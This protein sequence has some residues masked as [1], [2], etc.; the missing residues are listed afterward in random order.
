M[1]KKTEIY[2]I[3]FNHV[4]TE[5]DMYSTT[6][7]L[8]VPANVNGLFVIPLRIITDKDYKRITTFFDNDTSHTIALSDDVEI[9][10]RVIKPKTDKD[11]EKIQNKDK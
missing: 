11:A 2:Q 5:K 1:K 3:R 8:G 4:R 10:K 7:T 6:Y 9:F